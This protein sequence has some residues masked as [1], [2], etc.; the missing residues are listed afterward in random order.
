M[1]N[2]TD[3]RRSDEGSPGVS[4]RPA[5]RAAAR[6]N[7]KAPAAKPTEAKPF[8]HFPTEFQLTSMR[9]TPHHPYIDGNTLHAVRGALAE[10]IDYIEFDLVL[11]RDGEL[12][13]AHQP[14][15]EDCG[16][17]SKLG[18]DQVRGCRVKGSLKLAELGEI[19]SLSFKGFFL[20]LKDT[21]QDDAERAQAAVERA[22]EA[23]VAAR[24]QKQ[25]VLMLYQTP[26]DAVHVVKDKGLRAGIKGYPESEAD[27]R[28]M[29]ERAARASF[30]MVSVNV[31]Y[32][33]QEIIEAS[34]ALGVWHLPWSTDPARADHWRELAQAGVGGLIVLHLELAEKSVAPH[35]VD[36]RSLA[37]RML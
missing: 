17:I 11:T 18:L 24:K 33:N 8:E 7:A 27:T 30:E 36:V 5:S 4:A 10:G 16:T 22:A 26:A 15:V 21:K 1:P 23:V 2:P 31:D 19:L 9:A 13:T 34:A 37:G 3:S 6:P 12:V 14:Y 35:W 25:A 28:Q 20:D 29:V 32:V